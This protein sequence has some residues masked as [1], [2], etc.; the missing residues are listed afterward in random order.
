[1]RD[2][3]LLNLQDDNNM[4]LSKGMLNDSRD[5]RLMSYLAADRSNSELKT[6]VTSHYNEYLDQ[7]DKNFL[8]LIREDEDEISEC[9]VLVND[10]H[11]EISE[12]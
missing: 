4:S 2:E 5:K 7:F 10:E 11:I 12:S 6:S 1:M 9:D 8:Q 3:L